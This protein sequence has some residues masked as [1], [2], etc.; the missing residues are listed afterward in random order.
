M[1]PRPALCPLYL[2][3][4]LSHPGPGPLPPSHPMWEHLGSVYTVSSANTP[5]IRGVKNSSSNS[6]S[7]LVQAAAADSWMDPVKRAPFFGYKT[8]PCEPEARVCKLGQGLLPGLVPPEPAAYT[9]SSPASVPFCLFCCPSLASLP[10]S[11]SP[12]S[13]SSVCLFLPTAHCCPTC[14]LLRCCAACFSQGPH[15]LTVLTM[16]TPAWEAG[17]ASP[18]LMGLTIWDSTGPQRTIC[19]RGRKSM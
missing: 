1:S 8:R 10:G 13:I 16:S 14:R 9:V 17:A 3:V 7:S 2:G 15:N 5:P 18:R 19:A 11:I 6:Y 12:G 4:S